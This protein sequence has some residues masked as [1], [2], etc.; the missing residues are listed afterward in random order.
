MGASP[1]INFFGVDLKKLDSNSNNLRKALHIFTRQP[2]PQPGLKPQSLREMQKMVLSRPSETALFYKDFLEMVRASMLNNP[3]EVQVKFSSEFND[4][5]L[6]FEE[7]YASRSVNVLFLGVSEVE[8]EQKTNITETGY[9][10]F[11]ERHATA[12]IFKKEVDQLV[13]TYFNSH[14]KKGTNHLGQQV[15]Q[16]IR[17]NL[18]INV[19][20]IFREEDVCPFFQTGFQGGNC[21]LWQLLILCLFMLNQQYISTPNVIYKWI[22]N[23]NPP[24]LKEK[25]KKSNSDYLIILFEMFTWYKFGTRFPY[26]F[27]VLYDQAQTPRDLQ[28]SSLEDIYVRSYLN[29]NLRVPWC[30]GIY[31]KNCPVS[32]C[33]PIK[34]KCEYS[35]HTHATILELKD[36]LQDLIQNLLQEAAASPRINL[37]EQPAPV[38]PYRV[39]RYSQV[40]HYVCSLAL[41]LITF[42][43]CFNGTTTSL[44]VARIFSSSFQVNVQC[45]EL[46]QMI[47]TLFE[48]PT[49]EECLDYV[50]EKPMDTSVLQY[51]CPT[52]AKLR[53][54]LSEGKEEEDLLVAPDNMVLYTT[55]KPFNITLSSSLMQLNY[56]EEGLPLCAAVNQPENA[57]NYV[58]FK[59]PT[60]PRLHYLDK[61]VWN[62]FLQQIILTQNEFKIIKNARDMQIE[63]E[64]INYFPSLPVITQP[65]VLTSLL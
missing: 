61:A 11:V 17:D 18:H 33:T 14:S 26:Y 31:A 65:P 51:H 7:W 24:F 16:H 57:Y 64:Q 30:S 1:S 9:T 27:Q 19:F 20:P 13:L 34:S 23:Q 62:G 4:L 25:N 50:Y 44:N 15:S 46:L 28:I 52:A 60:T 45:V 10:L 48:W 6:I 36:I 47:L 21:S 43:Y 39:V 42:L 49:F 37:L 56:E 5:I 35:Q 8:S 32:D 22:E 12:F 3:E 29:N 41:D 40:Q 53:Y 55:S 38:E 2:Y 58:L 54:L 59:K 63:T